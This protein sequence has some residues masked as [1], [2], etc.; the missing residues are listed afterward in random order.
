MTTSQKRVRA[1]QALKREIPGVLAEKRLTRRVYQS[2]KTCARG[3][4]PSW[5]DIKALDL[6]VDWSS[7]F[8][9]DLG[10]SDSFAYFI[11]LGEDVS[12]LSYVTM[13]GEC[14]R[15]MSVL[16]YAA[17]R[18]DEAVLSRAP[19]VAS[20]AERVLDG[21]RAFFRTILM[22]LS[23]NGRDVTHIFGSAT[24]KHVKAH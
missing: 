16:D 3:G 9:V 17:S 6:G 20:G 10:L 19:V 5:D 21:G 14:G 8:A 23:Q 7:C 13:V 4:L 22:P 2:W 11:Y 1:M 15:E 12:E 18:M 24:G